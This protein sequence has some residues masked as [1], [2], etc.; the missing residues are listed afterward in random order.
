MAGHQ[1]NTYSG[2]TADTAW[3]CCEN[4]SALGFSGREKGIIVLFPASENFYESARHY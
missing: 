3:P 2:S 1:G 4:P